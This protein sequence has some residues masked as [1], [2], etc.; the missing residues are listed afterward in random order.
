[1]STVRRTDLTVLACFPRFRLYFLVIEVC[2]KSCRRVSHGLCHS[3][4]CIKMI[5]YPVLLLHM[6]LTEGDCEASPIA[7]IELK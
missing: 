3:T 4:D 1:M 5:V 6:F 7:V 2:D